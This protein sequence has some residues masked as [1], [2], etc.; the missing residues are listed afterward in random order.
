ML[1]I[2]HVFGFEVDTFV[3]FTWAVCGLTLVA[4]AQA[5]LLSRNDPSHR[6]RAIAM[7]ICMVAL[8]AIGFAIGSPFS[9]VRWS[10][11]GGSPRDF[12]LILAAPTVPLWGVAIIF[13][14]VGSV[15]EGRYA[16]G[17]K[18]TRERCCPWCGYPQSDAGVR[19]PECGNPAI[20]PDLPIAWPDPP[21]RSVTLIDRS[22]LLYV[23]WTLA[24]RRADPP[25]GVA[26]QL[27]V[28]IAKQFG[29]PNA[30]FLPG[31]AWAL[32]VRDRHGSAKATIEGVLGLKLTHAEMATFGRL[33][34][35]AAADRLASR[36]GTVR[37]KPP[38]VSAGERRSPPNGR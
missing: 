37:T 10:A 8:A 22:R 1:A 25:D 21:P 12:L 29:W 31:D 24:L 26:G 14:L 35:G 19:C 5:G 32:L 15:G 17:L 27:A 16:R 28:A 3:A 6:N 30:R 11:N 13:V 36:V 9:D 4:A 34:L 33:T 18:R 23:R 7:A 20:R 38:M 2:A